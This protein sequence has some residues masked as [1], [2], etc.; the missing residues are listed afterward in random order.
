MPDGYRDLIDAFLNQ[1]A[2]DATLRKRIRENPQEALK[3]AGFGQIL[4]PE[5]FQ[6]PEVM[7]YGQCADTCFNRWTCLSASCFITI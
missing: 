1:V 3:D 5:S 4:Q 2:N 6:E 7:G